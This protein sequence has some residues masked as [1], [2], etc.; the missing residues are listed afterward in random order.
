MTPSLHFRPLRPAVAADGP[1]TLELLIQIA[2]P[3][4]PPAQQKNR[5]GLNL[6][7]VI[8][9][10][11]SMMAGSKI[12]YARKAARF[13]AG[14]LTDRDRLAIITFDDEVQVLVP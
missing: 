3:A 12:S 6:A 14:E 1:T 11:G 10:S 4:L 8:D 9:R 13:L 2:T 5:P 7:L